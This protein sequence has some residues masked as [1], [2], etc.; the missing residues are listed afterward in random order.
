M[1]FNTVNRSHRKAGLVSALRPLGFA[2]LSA[3]SGLPTLAQADILGLS[4][5]VSAWYTGVDGD[6]KSGGDNLGLGNQLGLED[7]FSGQLFAMFENPIPLIPNVRVQYSSISMDG[8]GRVNADVFNRVSLDGA[9]STSFDIDQTDA[10]VFW[11]LLDTVVHIDFGLQVKFV[12]GSIK[13]KEER[14]LGN[15]AEQDF[16][17]VLPMLYGGVGLDLPLT[18]LSVY[19]SVAGIGYSGNSIVDVNLA[20][21]YEVNIVDVALGWREE[22]IEL[23]DVDD[24]DADFT[25]GGPYVGVGLSF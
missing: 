22:Q 4:A 17:V 15:T 19:G 10:I 5:G 1:T 6:I 9:T 3:S 2:V 14:P 20:L 18:G 11:E 21:T 25:L 7:E 8:D 16:S 24:T 13:I 23:D 12:D